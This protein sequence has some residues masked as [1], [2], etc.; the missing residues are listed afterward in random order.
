MSESSETDK[1]IRVSLREVTEKTVISVCM[2]SDTLAGPQRK[3]VAPNAVSIAQAYF[4]KHA[5]FRAIYAEETLVGFL[6]LD[7]NPDIP[8][9]FLWRLMI[10]TPYQGRGYGRQAVQQLIE[11]V[12]TRPGAREL[13]VSCG[14]GEG[15][16]E[17][18]Y[19]ALG[20]E[21]TGEM[22][23]DEVVLRLAL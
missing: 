12:K 9:Y 17:G 15:S 19:R 14:E 13:R 6:M 4:A 11:Y 7:D 8:D 22:E 23:E 3:M 2:L 21:R 16:P 18:F 1:T 20:F 5:W 10:A